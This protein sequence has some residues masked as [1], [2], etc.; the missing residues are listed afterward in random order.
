MSSHYFDADPHSTSRPAEV[1][2]LLADRRLVLAT[3]RGMFSPDRVDPGTRV[4]LDSVPPPPAEGTLLDLGCGYGPIALTMA[5]RAPGARVLGVDVNGRAVARA[6]ENATR[7]HLDNV[8]FVQVDETAAPVDPQAAPGVD[9]PFAALWSNPPIRIGKD[10]LR[11]L[12][13][14]WLD[15]LAPEAHAHLVAHKHLGAD[16]LQRW[17]DERGNACERL[18]SRS[19]YRVLRVAATR[20]QRA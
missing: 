2:L 20:T 11:A 19:G 10:A 13:A 1:S 3:D 17:L 7:N 16:S 4:L 12:L 8:D 15:R 9:G 6:R 18:T 14:L 5:A